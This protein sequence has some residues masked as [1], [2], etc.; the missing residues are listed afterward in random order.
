MGI[1]TSHDPMTYISRL[2]TSDF[3]QFCM[4]KVF[5]IGRVLSFVDGSKLI[6]F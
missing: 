4:V 6:F 5:V 1:Y 3:G 2:L